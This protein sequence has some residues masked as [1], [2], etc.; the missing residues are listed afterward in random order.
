MN[1]PAC[2]QNPL[3]QTF[4]LLAALLLADGVQ[5]EWFPLG[6]SDNF[7]VYLDQRSIQRNGDSALTWQ[8]MD[9]V[10]AQWTDAHT[11]IGSIKNLVEYDCTQPRLRTLAAEAYSEQMAVG[12]LVAKEQIPSPEWE[13]V[14]PGSAAEQILKLV[15]VK[16]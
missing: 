9:F 8:L 7:R 1:R 16:K 11:V 4:F 6:R 10:T 3:R 13:A 12:K 14:Q 15:C 2:Y 5:A